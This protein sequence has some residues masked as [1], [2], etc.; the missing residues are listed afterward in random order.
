MDQPPSQVPSI[1]QD[2]PQG[3]SGSFGVPQGGNLS[4]D[5]GLSD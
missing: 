1:G 4:N 2:M 5:V 3:N